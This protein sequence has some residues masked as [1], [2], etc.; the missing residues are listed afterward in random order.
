MAIVPTEAIVKDIRAIAAKLRCQSLSRVE[1]GQ[2]GGKYSHHHLYDSGCSWNELCAAAGIKS[3]QIEPVPDEV[4]YDRLRSAI[5]GLGRYPR[6]YERKKFGLNFKKSRW[7]TLNAFVQHAI[8]EGV[9]EPTGTPVR[10]D[11]FVT[12]AD[13]PNRESS[14]AAPT[15]RRST[16]KGRSTPPIPQRTRRLK[17][18][19][20]DVAG[21]PYAPHDELGVV[22]LFAILCGQGRLPWEIL[23]LSGGKGIDAICWDRD[24]KREVRVEFKHTLSRHSWNHSFDDL[25]YVVC[26]ENRWRDN[27][28]KPVI[29]LREMVG[30]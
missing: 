4:Y 11:V 6:T 20:I 8:E 21:F 26:W 13:S 22:S 30:S 10:C 29:K 15:H 9:I 18:R 25:D 1:Y 3:K 5:Q 27:C 28:P 16:A 2:A 12:T 23:E 14:V 19:R 24:D 7:P 17:W